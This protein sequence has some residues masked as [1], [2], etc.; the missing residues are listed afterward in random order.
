MAKPDQR[1]VTPLRELLGAAEALRVPGFPFTWASLINGW[2][3]FGFGLPAMLI[4]AFLCWD[5]SGVV[6]WTI[7]GWNKYAFDAWFGSILYTMPCPLRTQT[8]N[9][10]CV[11][12]SL[13]FGLF[14]GRLIRRRIIAV[15]AASLRTLVTRCVRWLLVVLSICTA[16]TV[17]TAY[18]EGLNWRFDSCVESP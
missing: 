7:V 13:G 16:V 9:E 3:N 17:A 14:T 11:L 10:V 12:L 15:D 4:V 18:S 6:M 1:L 8:W 2:A 5:L